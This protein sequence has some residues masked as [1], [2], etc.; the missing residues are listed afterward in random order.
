MTIPVVHDAAALRVAVA[1][2]RSA[3]QRIALVPTMGAL[4][5]GHVALVEAAR[6]S[7]DRVVVTIFVNPMQFAP[8]E[9]FTAYPRD[10]DADRARVATAGADLVYAPELPD[11]YP[12][13]FC[14]TVS[15]GGPAAAGLEDRFRPTHFAGV[16]TIV[17]K[18]L[19][20][21]LP[22]V[23]LFGEKD[24]Q[25]LKVIQ[26][27]V[28]DL[29]LPVGVQ[30]RPTVR[31]ADGLA[32]SS[33]NAYLDAAERARASALHRI[34][35]GCAAALGQRAS[36]EQS[37]A[38]ARG[39]IEEAGFS[40]DY[41]DVREADTLAIWDGASNRSGRLLAAARLGRTRLIDNVEIAARPA[42]P[43]A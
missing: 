34:L 40:L 26:Q 4:H 27:L 38:E 20:Q 5:A 24:W 25:Q 30:G 8:G 37:L 28:R 3:G 31:E 2:W 41:L 11:M 43:Q 6:A 36:P 10:L 19:L 9:D 39:M 1:G 32:M 17:T 16:A 23:A 21:T 18:I 29:D 35:A 12:P 33:R 42:L 7:A 22:D 13:G 14:T 15:L